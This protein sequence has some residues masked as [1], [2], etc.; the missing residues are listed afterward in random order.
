MTSAIPAIGDALLIIDVQNDFL[1]G[2][3]LAVP[4]G[5]AVIAPLNVAI[6]AF[7]RKSLPI[8]ASRDWHPANHCSFKA[9]GGIWPP[10]CIAGSSGAAF[11]AGLRIPE[12][13]LV[14]SKA[15]LPEADAYSAFDG[16][17]LADEL[18]KMGVR[19]LIVGGLATDYCVLATVRDALALGLDVVVLTDAIRA[20]DV[21]PGDGRAAI[22]KM[23][24]GR[25]LLLIS[26]DCR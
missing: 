11:A 19:R 17:Q 7:T 25:A 18:H 9:Q 2:G 20:V 12:T 4:A 16:T 13:A 14:V 26:Q 3:S 23:A 15:M 24:A 10:H 8:I 1:P 6:A 21:N 22:E 5:D